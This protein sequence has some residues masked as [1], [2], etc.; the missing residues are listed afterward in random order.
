MDLWE[1]MEYVGEALVFVGVVG[2]VFAEWHE[3]ECKRLAKA[4]SLVLIVGLG[5]SL[6][7]LVE[8]NEYFNGT[9]ASL[10]LKS[11]QANERAAKDEAE[12]A[13]LKADNLNLGIELENEQTERL[14][15]E[16]RVA[17]RHLGPSE[18]ADLVEH[19]K[20]FSG[21][22]Y[23]LWT[24]EVPD[25]EIGEFSVNLES[26]LGDGRS[27]AGWKHF[28]GGKIGDDTLTGIT[29]EVLSSRTPSTDKAANALALWLSK[30]GR[31]A[32]KKLVSPKQA[33][34]AETFTRGSSDPAEGIA[35]IIGKR[36]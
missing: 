3:P 9:I 14:K 4:S 15:L 25:Q 36:P 1:C 29:V 20:Q 16:K 34:W 17:W 26:A 13:R 8:T 19:V 35:I 32:I 10:N 18:R 12:A 7:A 30:H 24:T 31:T 2:E 28:F 11:S 27:G 23:A 6:A 5:L 22:K 21:Q 33:L